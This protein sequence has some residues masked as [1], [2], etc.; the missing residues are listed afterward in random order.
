MLAEK[1]YI[2]QVKLL[3]SHIKRHVYLYLMDF[4]FWF[5]L[6]KVSHFYKIIMLLNNIFYYT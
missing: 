3:L 4:L 1:S 2:P 5:I 6:H